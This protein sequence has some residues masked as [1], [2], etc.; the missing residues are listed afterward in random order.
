MSVLAWATAYL[1]ALVLAA[2]VYLLSVPSKLLGGLCCNVM[3]HACDVFDGKPK[4]PFVEHGTVRK[5][6]LPRWD[7]NADDNKA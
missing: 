5:P 6:P 7:Q 4:F 3:D 1:V 2:V